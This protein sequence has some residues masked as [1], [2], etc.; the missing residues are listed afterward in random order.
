MAIGTVPEGELAKKFDL[1]V[2]GGGPSGVAGAMQAA[3]LGKRVLLVDRPK[4][5]PPAG[6]LDPFFGGPTGL[7][8]KALRDCA[9]LYNVEGFDAIGLDR[10][11][12]FQQVRNSCLKLARNNAQSQ[13]DLLD[14]FKV[15]YL[16][17]EA[18][19]SL[20]A[21]GDVRLQVRPHANS[22]HE[23][24]VSG[25]R[26]LLCTG[27]YPFRPASIPFNSRCI[28]DSDTVNGLSF[29]PR[30]VVVAGSGIIAIEMAMIFRRLGSE[31]TMVVRG[32]QQIGIGN[33]DPCEPNLDG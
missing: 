1:L 19:L 13:T 2:I 23:V 29:L 18:T 33:I 20:V 32:K 4:A 27:S 14:K 3:N 31:V 6:G 9:K 25:T 7:F 16:Q 28:L 5:A 11:V 24:T 26:V 10:D 12:I 15:S 30:S 8:S 21:D 17:G 22:T